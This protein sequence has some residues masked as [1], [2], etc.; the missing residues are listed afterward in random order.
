M[1]F[2]YLAGTAMVNLADSSGVPQFS[3]VSMIHECSPVELLT[4]VIPMHH[5]DIGHDQLKHYAVH[6][7]LRVCFRIAVA[8]PTI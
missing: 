8:I 3:R 4:R 1:C 5:G 7:G 6:E 2:K